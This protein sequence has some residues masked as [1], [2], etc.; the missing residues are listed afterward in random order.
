MTYNYGLDK[1]EKHNNPNCNK[2][3]DVTTKKSNK[4]NKLIPKL[5]IKFKSL[6][7]SKSD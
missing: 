3:N 1:Q 6:Y 7:K 2:N 5:N 4:L